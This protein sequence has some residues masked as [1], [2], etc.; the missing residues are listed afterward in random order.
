[1]T[2]INVSGVGVDLTLSRL[3]PE[4]FLKIMA[5]VDL[6]DP[7]ALE[8]NYIEDILVSSREYSNS[9]PLMGSYSVTTDND[10]T[11]II[12]SPKIIRKSRDVGEKGSFYLLSVAE[13]SE[14]S[15]HTL[16][17]DGDI[18]SSNL[19]IEHE[20]IRI[21]EVEELT[22]DFLEGIHYNDMYFEFRDASEVDPITCYLI[23]DKGC[24]YSLSADETYVEAWENGHLRRI[25]ILNLTKLID[26]NDKS[27]PIW[28]AAKALRGKLYLFDWLSEVEN[29]ELS[30]EMG[31]LVSSAA[32][33]LEE[34]KLTVGIFEEYLYESSHF[35]SYMY[36]NMSGDRPDFDKAISCLTK[37]LEGEF[38]NKNIRFAAET[39]KL[40]A[41]Y[42]ASS[43]KPA[44]SINDY[45]EAISRFEAL[46]A[47][48]DSQ[49]DLYKKEIAECN[50]S[51]GLL[52]E[53]FGGDYL[54]QLSE[55]VELNPECIQMIVRVA[56]LSRDTV[57]AILSS[58]V[59]SR[60]SLKKAILFM[61]Y[62]SEE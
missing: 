13:S 5:N 43:K 1:M 19:L 60:D 39:F 30:K 50:Y 28:H 58:D 6:I 20:L 23:D 15:W 62:G 51:L 47:D 12:D 53:K 41:N 25:A 3:T 29:A 8:W 59:L 49:D 22:F 56:K 37:G 61:S 10:D 42:Y 7:T 17:V 52:L 40:R 31:I 21:L 44:L 36:A 11:Q 34:V 45:K 54:K 55:A 16:E 2:F 38:P 24:V 35:L 46:R 27:C 9:N 14:D 48:D 4:M 32:K 57:D 33:D 26:S 18:D